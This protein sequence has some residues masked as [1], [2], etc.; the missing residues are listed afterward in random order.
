ML[1]LFRKRLFRRLLFIRELVATCLLRLL[2]Q[3]E[4]HRGQTKPCYENCS[5][6][7]N[8]FGTRV[9]MIWF[10]SACSPTTSGTTKQVFGR[11]HARLT[12]QKLPNCGRIDVKIVVSDHTFEGDRAW[13][14]FTMKWTDLKTGETRTRAGMQVVRIEAGQLC[15]DLG[16][17]P[18]ARL[19]MDGPRCAGALDERAANQVSPYCLPT[20]PSICKLVP[21]KGLLDAW[22]QMSNYGCP[23]GM[24]RPVSSGMRYAPNE[25]RARG[26]T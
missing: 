21:G 20:I 12:Q 2:N 5:T 9:N 3:K 17:V 26:A 4:T 18:T 8:E 15:G 19:G 10:L 13:F 7:G 6:D 14:R 24:R 25:R 22:I 16:D 23:D 1:R 11:E